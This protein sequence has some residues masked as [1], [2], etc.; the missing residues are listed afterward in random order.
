M[1]QRLKALIKRLFMRPVIDSNGDQ[2][3]EFVNQY[4]DLNFNLT[5]IAA[6]KLATLVVTESNVD[7]GK[8][9]DESNVRV[10]L[11][12]DLIQKVWAKAKKITAQAFGTGGVALVPYCVKDTIYFDIVQ[13]NRMVIASVLGDTITEVSF[14]SDIL[15][16]DDDVYT[17]YT[18][19]EITDDGCVIKN[20]A[21]KNGKTEIALT[22]VSAWKNIP[23]EILIPNCKKVPVAYLKCPTDNRRSSDLMGVPITYGCQYIM[24]EILACL[25][26]IKDEYGLKKPI[27][28]ADSTLF[29]PDEE[30]DQRLYKTFTGGKLSDSSLIDIF[31]PQIRDTAYYK[32]LESLFEIM[33]KSM[34]TSKGI[35]SEPATNY[36]TA[37]EIKRSIYDTFALVEN[38]RKS[39]EKTMQDMLDAY[40]V[41]CD[42]YGLA[43][44]YN[45][46]MPLK[47]DWSYGLV[48][49]SEITFQQLMEG[50]GIGAISEAEIRQFI[51][52]KETLAEAQRAVDEI[53]KDKPD[54]EELFEYDDKT[55]I[56]ETG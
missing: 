33:E 20:K 19:Y 51:K 50:N 2:S 6:N 54:V 12:N 17:R 11:M 34:G 35:L 16:I 22:D 31:D 43:P 42:Y 48:E 46:D 52:P 32:R 38:M 36:A 30:V 18:Y 14:L 21:C 39:W 24:S 28:F 29:S 23:P 7:V 5:A 44:I 8:G 3:D 4:K 10:K 56:E 9:K 1:W 41:I 49:S 40:N 37:T 13:Q 27:I 15:V 45:G 25:D 53:Q 47:F 26:Q 55:V